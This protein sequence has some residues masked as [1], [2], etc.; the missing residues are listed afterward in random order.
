MDHSLEEPPTPTARRRRGLAPAGWRRSRRAPT[1]HPHTGL[2]TPLP[3]TVGDELDRHRP[4]AA[5]TTAL[6]D[7]AAHTDSAPRPTC[8]SDEYDPFPPHHPQ[9]PSPPHHL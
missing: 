2:L 9:D 8:P 4:R 3:A 6:D 5:L 1:H 7:L